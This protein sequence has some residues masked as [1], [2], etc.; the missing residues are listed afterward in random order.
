M[1]KMY[2]KI[3]EWFT[4]FIYTELLQTRLIDNQADAIEK[5]KIQ[6]F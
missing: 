2:K 5:L 6:V 1:I 4:R 3:I